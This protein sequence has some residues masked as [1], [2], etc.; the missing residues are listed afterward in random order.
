M[1]PK[2]PKIVNSRTYSRK[3]NCPGIK[4]FVKKV[5]FLFFLKK[6]NNNNLNLNEKGQKQTR[7]PPAP[8][9]YPSALLVKQQMT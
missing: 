5:H 2:S 1:A 7:P 3:I 6:N 4:R 9:D 8:L